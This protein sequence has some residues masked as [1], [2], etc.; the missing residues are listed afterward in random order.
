MT[1][2]KDVA[3]TV[4]V[5]TA[6]V[7]RA[8]RGLPRVS[9]ETRLRVLQ[10]AA[11]L[12]YVA[13]PSAAGL[14]T[15]QTRAV[16]VVVPFVSRWFYGE[17]V[18]GADTPLRDAGYDLLL[19]NL[20][21]DRQTRRRVFGTHLSSK[22]VDAVL[23]LSLTPTD[24]E[25]AW[26]TKLDRPVAV[27]GASVPG[28]SSVRIDDEATACIA[29]KHLL[30][31]GHRDIG[32]I[33][34]SLEDQLDFAAPFDRLLGYRRSMSHAGLS[35]LPQWEAVGNFTVRGGLAAMR[36]LLE[37]EPRPTAV[38]A[39]S[40]E[41]AIGAVHAVRE[42]GLRVPQDLSV[43]GIDGHEMAEYFDLT[44]VAQPVHE[45]GRLAAQLLLDVLATDR[46]HAKQPSAVTVPTRLVVRH[47]TG[48][49]AS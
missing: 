33:G 26:L 20:G 10:A 36:L 40:D 6:T 19:Y 27:V 22:R 32:Y 15:G 14:A 7:S 45:Q 34:G 23:V 18:Q 4:G 21:G 31:L 29:M 30:A 42:A 49:P 41:M 1:S 35:V 17:V 8:L 5:S 12:D 44:T 37:S 39:A 2:I 48:P 38:F 24:E 43:I 11:D 46:E 3:R 47:T 28:W 16:G 9:E 13:S 25:L